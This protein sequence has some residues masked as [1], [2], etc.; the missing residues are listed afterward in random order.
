MRREVRNIFWDPI[1]NEDLEILSSSSV[2]IHSF[3]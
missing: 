3:I 1:D 2:G